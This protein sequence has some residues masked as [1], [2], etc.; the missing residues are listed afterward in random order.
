MDQPG[1][2]DKHG[3]LG[4]ASFAI[5]AVAL[6]MIAV[7]LIGLS[8]TDPSTLLDAVHDQMSDEELAKTIMREAPMLIIGVVLIAIASFLTFVGAVLG[9]AGLFVPD[10][11]RLFAALGTALNG[12]LVL[13]ALAIGIAGYFGLS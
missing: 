4:I 8:A 6:F 9:I 10:R 5:A 12:F 7:S 3:G 11:K 13:A 2:P 1:K